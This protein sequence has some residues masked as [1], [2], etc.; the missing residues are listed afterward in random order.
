MVQVIELLPSICEALV[1]IPSTAKKGINGG[2]G[3]SR[4]VLRGLNKIIIVK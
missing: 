1:S 3:I 2:N 4:A